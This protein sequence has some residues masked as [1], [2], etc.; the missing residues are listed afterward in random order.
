[1]QYNRHTSCVAIPSHSGVIAFGD[2][3]G[4]VRRR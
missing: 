1:M 2:I 4:N 3:A